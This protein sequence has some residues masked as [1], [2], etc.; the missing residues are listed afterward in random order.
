MIYKKSKVSFKEKSIQK[1]NETDLT[2]LEG[3]VGGISTA[4]SIFDAAQTAYNLA[5]ESWKAL[6]DAN[7]LS[8]IRTGRS[9]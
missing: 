1:A 7:N 4:L 3:V 2:T 6:Q 9:R 5:N 8:T